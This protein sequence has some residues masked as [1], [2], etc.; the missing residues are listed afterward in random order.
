MA[1]RADLNKGAGSYIEFTLKIDRPGKYDL[2]ISLNAEG[3]CELLTA[4]VFNDAKQA[5]EGY[6]MT[7]LMD[8]EK[9]QSE[10]FDLVSRE[11]ALIR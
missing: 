10:T 9:A 5:D 4:P 7:K 3:A 6:P 2:S 1:V 11:S 8:I